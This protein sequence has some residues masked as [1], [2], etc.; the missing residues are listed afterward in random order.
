MVAAMWM[1]HSACTRLGDGLAEKKAW[2]TVS[3][4]QASSPLF[5]AFLSMRST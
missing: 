3:Q 2:G 5:T 4:L 1:S